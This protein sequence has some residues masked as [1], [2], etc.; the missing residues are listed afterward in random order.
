MSTLIHYC[1]SVGLLN[2]VICFQNKN[3][4]ELVPQTTYS[5]G[6]PSTTDAQVG[7]TWESLGPQ[8]GGFVGGIGKDLDDDMRRYSPLASR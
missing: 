1:L 5:Q 3:G 6:K 4:L 2:Y 7:T 8:Q